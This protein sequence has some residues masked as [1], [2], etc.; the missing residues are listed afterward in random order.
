MSAIATEPALRPLPA[1][2]ARAAERLVNSALALDE[3]SRAAL[4][5]LSGRQVCFELAPPG[6]ASTWRIEGERLRCL[7]PE[8]PELAQPSHITMRGSPAA[9]ARLLHENSAAGL[10][11]VHVQGD[12][13]IARALMRLFS[14]LHIDWEEA[15]AARI[16]DGAAHRTARA[17]RG[18]REWASETA[19]LQTDNTLNY[20]REERQ[21]LPSEAAF[22]RQQ[23][24]V[25][26]LRAALDRLEQRVAALEKSKPHG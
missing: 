10:P 5:Q 7:A 4:T 6:W 19:S 17:L 3:D 14:R 24:A 1:P 11:G 23:T 22:A 16:G 26:S 2:L 8:A 18:L 13:D 12:V 9:F 25:D 15:I 20:L 21:W